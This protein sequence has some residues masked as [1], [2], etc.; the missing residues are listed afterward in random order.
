M[1]NPR[2]SL[3]AGIPPC[4]DKAERLLRTR[5]TERLIRTATG[6]WLWVGIGSLTIWSVD[7]VLGL[8][9][10]LQGVLVG[11][12]CLPYRLSSGFKGRHTPELYF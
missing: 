6:K 9:R 1:F 10:S 8:Y 4:L 12:I 3:G 2:V 11:G 5:L 7:A